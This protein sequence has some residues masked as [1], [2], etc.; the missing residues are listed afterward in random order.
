MNEYPSNDEKK[1]TIVTSKVIYNDQLY[2][3]VYNQ[4]SKKTS[5]VTYLKKEKE[6]VYIDQLEDSYFKYIPIN[7]ELLQ[8]EVVILAEKP[9]EYDNEKQLDQETSEYIN[10]YVDVSK[11]HLKQDTWYVKLSWVLDNLYTVPYLRALGDYGTGKTR[12]LDVIGGICYKPMFIGGAVRSAPIF[13]VIDQ[14]RGTAIFDEFTLKQSDETQDIIQ[15]LNNGFQR[16]KSVLRCK[17]GNYD[18][19]IPFDPFG[20]KILATKKEF[21]DSALESRCITEILRE[22]NRTDIPIDLGKSFFEKRNDLQNKLL[23]YRLKNWDKINPDE[24]KKVNFGH[25]QPRIKQC[26][27]PFTVLFAHDE[28]ILQQ[29]IQEVKIYNNRLIESNSTSFDGQIINCF[30]K[31]KIDNWKYITSKDIRDF[32]VNEFNFK[33][34]LNERTIGKHLKTLGFNSNPEKTPN[35]TKRTIKIEDC[36]LKRLVFRYADPEM[37]NEILEHILKDGSQKKLIGEEDGLQ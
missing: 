26:F 34:S 37:Q 30:I 8:K 5:Y 35:G 13:R 7:N 18:T 17:D 22:T 32:L 11:V 20:A 4:K 15:I 1:P 10:E 14:W 24:T 16:G 29:F 23:M 3:Q 25:V 19:V 6:I 9:I 2:E 21:K 31:M 33:D 28:N 36:H 27:L 12:Y